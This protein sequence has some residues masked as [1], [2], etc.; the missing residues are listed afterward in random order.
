MDDTEWICWIEGGIGVEDKIYVNVLEFERLCR[1]DG[2]M[3]ALMSFIDKVEK[4]ETSASYLDI[5]TVKA[6]IGMLDD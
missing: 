1:L 3:D 6:I 4:S 2:R 5:D